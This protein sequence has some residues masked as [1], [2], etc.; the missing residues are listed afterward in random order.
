ML[1]VITAGCKTVTPTVTVAEPRV[2]TCGTGVPNNEIRPKNAVITIYMEHDSLNTAHAP[3]DGIEFYRVTD[4]LTVPMNLYK[5]LYAHMR[6][7][8]MLRENDI[9]GKWIYEMSFDQ[10]LLTSWTLKKGVENGMVMEKEIDRVLTKLK[11]DMRYFSKDKTTRIITFK[12]VLE[13]WD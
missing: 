3:A 10:Q 11:R 1:L 13:E 9:Q 6:Y 8:E 5:E 7:P 12:V 2:I 4:S